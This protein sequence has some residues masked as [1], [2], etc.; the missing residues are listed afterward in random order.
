MLSD[1]QKR[2]SIHK[3]AEALIPW[4]CFWV[5]FAWG[6]RVQNIFTHLPAYGDVLEVLWGIRYYYDT[7]MVKRSSPLFTSIVFHPIGWHTPTLAH[8]PL[9]FLLSLPLN[10]LGG[11]A[12]AYNLLAVLALVVSFAGMYRFAQLFVSWPTAVL[13]AVV[14]TFWRMVW[15]RVWGHLHTEWMSGLLPWLAYG[16]MRVRCSHESR[17]L[18]WVLFAGLI[19]GLMINFALYGVFIGAFVFLLWGCQIFR[20]ISQVVLIGLMAMVI[21]LPTILLYWWGA[22]QDHIHVFGAGHNL[23]WGA[24]L[25]SLF[26]PSVFHPL[27]LVRSISHLLYTGPHD[28]S[29]VMNFGIMTS[30]LAL[31]GMVLVV[32]SRRR[33]T[34]LV[35]LMFGGMV[36]SMGLLL[37][38]NGEVVSY[39]AFRSLNAAI[40][41]LGHF[42]K[43]EIFPS[44]C[45]KPFETGVPLP[46]FLFT[47]AIPFWESARTVSRFAVL[48]MLGAA[49]LAGI[50]L[51]RLPKIARAFLSVLWM[52]EMLPSPTGNVPV[53]FQLHPAY[54][55][56]AGQAVGAGEGIA[57]ISYPT[58]KVGG[59]ILWAA[60]LHSKPTVSG[61]GSFWPEHTF[62]LWNYFVND[63]ASFSRP[64]VGLILQQYQVRYLFLHILG[65]REKEMWRMVQGNPVFRPVGCFDPMPSPNPW[66]YPI[67][68]AEVEAEEN[69]IQ[70]L[71]GQGWS[72]REE[73]GVWVEGTYSTAGWIA[74]EK[75]DYVLRVSA[76]PFCVPAQHQRISI[77]IN[78]EKIGSYQWGECELWEAEIPIPG[79][80][81]R[82]GWNEISF[83]YAYA[84]SPAEVTLGQNP[85]S[86]VLSVGFTTL[87]VK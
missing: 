41:N 46:G 75:R 73:W 57:D 5:F 58:L 27:R 74:A 28:E 29:G 66:P 47:A 72:G 42:L 32:K 36:L 50:A 22:Q 60:G 82:I 71:L 49:V 18:K 55:W 2:T 4:F 54:A 16:L 83:Q 81:V 11:S 77:A 10:A 68:V 45:P 51:D 35:G 26:V 59:E 87:E 64:Q 8:T 20:R 34:A 25:N 9:L 37:R 7:L 85:D 52:V 56:L 33:N 23:W 21:G 76:F 63:P 19:W 53:P 80:V 40:W 3:V 62:V 86:R 43:P 39:P 12:F 24:S 79:S 48:G 14:Y 17:Q 15:G 13:A 30:L 61:A 69:P 31:I 6:W 38:W 78:G 70:V 44:T 84:R 65:E 1:T 67:C